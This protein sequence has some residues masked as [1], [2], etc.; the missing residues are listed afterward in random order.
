MSCLDNDIRN[1]LRRDG[2]CR[3]DRWFV[4]LGEEFVKIDERSEAELQELTKAIA[5]GIIFYDL[6]N[7][8]NRDWSAFFDKTVPEAAPHMALFKA[9]L[10]MFAQAQNHVNTLTRSHLEHYYKTV[11]QLKPLVA[12]PDKAVVVW[13]LAKNVQKHLLI[14]RTPISAEKDKTQ[15]ERIYRTE[16]DTVLNRAYLDVV[17]QLAFDKYSIN[18]NGSF[19]SFT[20]P[21]SKKLATSKADLEK[22]TKNGEHWPLF[23]IQQY[24]L[25]APDRTMEDAEFGFAIAHPVLLMAEGRRR[26][27]LTLNFATAFDPS[28]FYPSAQFKYALKYYLSG[29]GQWLEVW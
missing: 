22:M 6:N 11:L 28:K 12:V 5:A 25:A 19:K 18:I 20:K 15:V 21:F 2:T 3:P 10:A 9:F 29:T 27:T 8:P 7:Q 4:A 17:Q 26:L 16:R 1:P 24:N 14:A 23:G 13:E